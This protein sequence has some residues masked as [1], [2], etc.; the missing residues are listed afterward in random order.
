VVCSDEY[1]KHPDHVPKE[2]LVAQSD[3]VIVGA[4]HRAYR[5][6]AFPKDKK[7]VDIWGILRPS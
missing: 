4:P 3:A 7:V 5:H 1:F 2:I 6:L